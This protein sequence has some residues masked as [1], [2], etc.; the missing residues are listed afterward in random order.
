MPLEA[1][2]TIASGRPFEAMVGS[3]LVS[4]F[5]EPLHP[6]ACREW[7]LERR[8]LGGTGRD[9]VRRDATRENLLLSEFQFPQV[10]A[11]VLPQIK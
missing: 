3:P 1:P 2:V 7:A 6:P 10:L 9:T 5:R 8:S 11:I 4:G